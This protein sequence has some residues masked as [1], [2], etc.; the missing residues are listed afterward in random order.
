MYVS[1][2]KSGQKRGFRFPRSVTTREEGGLNTCHARQAYVHDQHRMHTIGTDSKKNKIKIKINIKAVD[3][4][5]T[6]LKLRAA[7]VISEQKDRF[8]SR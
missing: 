4:L 1:V 6:G 2:T 7:A 8:V 5:L 3:S